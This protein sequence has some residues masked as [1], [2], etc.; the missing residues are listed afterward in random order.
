MLPLLGQYE[1]ATTSTGAP[2]M[3]PDFRPVAGPVLSRLGW[4]TESRLSPWIHRSTPYVTVS[5]PSAD[6]LV[7]L[8]VDRD[9]I[10]VIRNGVDVPTED[11][12]PA[13][14]AGPAGPPDRTQAPCTALTAG[15]EGRVVPVEYPQ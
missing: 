8:G 9:R 7:E 5:A 15:T 12:G 13:G 2:V 6:E 3:T 14:T 4:F 10:T 11:A 1:S